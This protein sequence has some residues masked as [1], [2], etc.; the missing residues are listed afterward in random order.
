VLH[1]DGSGIG[2]EKAMT[3]RASA[4]GDD[5]P[6]RAQIDAVTKKLVDDGKII[7]AGWLGLRLLSIPQNAPEIQVTEMRQAFFA[8]AQ[9]LFSS[10]LSILDP[11][12]EPTERDLARMSLI[13]AE[14]QTFIKDF[15]LRHAQTKGSA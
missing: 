11:G 3:G 6:T 4:M 5:A 1:A 7:E 12:S 9:H 13:D 10:I 14:L 15:K 8:G 2:E